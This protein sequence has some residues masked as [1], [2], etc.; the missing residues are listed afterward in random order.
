MRLALFEFSLI[1]IM[2]YR[3]W[4]FVPAAEIP[5]R[6]HPQF[7]VDQEGNQK[8]VLLT[9]DE[10]RRL[11]EIVEDQLD[12]VDLDEAVSQEKQF[13]PYDKARLDLGLEDRP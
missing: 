12:A 11:M 9:P 6:F 7:L 4:V 2:T 8:G 13:I 3:V 1:R 5:V 10:Y